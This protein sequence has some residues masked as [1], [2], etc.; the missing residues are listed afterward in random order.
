MSS[1]KKRTWYYVMKPAA[2]SI[3]CDKCNGANIDWSEWEGMIW[4]Y[5]CGI[6]TEGFPGIFDG[7]IPITVAG[8]LGLSFDRYNMI[9]E[10]V[11]YPR[12]INGRIEYFP[13]PTNVKSEML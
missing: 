4:C 3:R 6:D 1:N 11:E 13:E 2:Y 7:P 10:R 5:D 9:E 8:L 12:R